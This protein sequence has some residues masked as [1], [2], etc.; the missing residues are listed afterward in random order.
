MNTFR[1]ITLAHHH[2]RL[3]DDVER[4]AP[5]VCAPY[6]Q[7]A[8]ERMKLG[9]TA[10]YGDPFKGFYGEQEPAWFFLTPLRDFG[11]ITARTLADAD[12]AYRFII[13]TL[14]EPAAN[15]SSPTATAAT[16]SGSPLGSGALFPASPN[17]P[18]AT[19]GG[20]AATATPPL[21]VASFSVPS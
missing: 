11:I 6:L 15:D 4:C 17:P 1:A 19:H 18:A 5:P 2:A 16:G 3:V 13:N 8:Y 9:V 12:G 7:D 21:G 20:D 10:S 14:T